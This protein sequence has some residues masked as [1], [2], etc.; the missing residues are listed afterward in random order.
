MWEVEISAL[1]MSFP[2]KFITSAE[3]LEVANAIVVPVPTSAAILYY[4][5]LKCWHGFNVPD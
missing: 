1:E 2:F 3:K 4:L 5:G